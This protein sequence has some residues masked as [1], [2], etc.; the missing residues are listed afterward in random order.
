MI[1]I[2]S[3]FTARLLY[4]AAC[5]SLVVVVN[6]A[7]CDGASLAGADLRN[8][9]LNSV[10]APGVDL[11][12]AD[13]SGSN[14]AYA[15]LRGA[16]LAGAT[17][18]RVQGWNMRASDADLTSANLDFANL[19][20][21]FFSRAKLAGASLIQADLSVCRL[22]HAD[23]LGCTGS[24]A[25]FANATLVGARF[26]LSYHDLVAEVLRQH[27]GE[28][29]S[30]RMVAGLVKVSPGWCWEEFCRFRKKPAFAWAIVTLARYVDPEGP[31]A[32]DLFRQAYQWVQARHQPLFAQL[33]QGAA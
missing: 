24:G 31:H 20:H 2:R 13:L 3:R 27:A 1:Q 16:K 23:L 33:K 29:R 30:R 14:L 5:P 9:Y 32:P 8:A 22:D 17:L 7:A 19:K 10:E 12:G 25:T 21:G 6:R 11:T 18:D 26:S 4:E 15:N 28:S